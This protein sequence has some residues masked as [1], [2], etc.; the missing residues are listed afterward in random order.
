[1]TLFKLTE[2]TSCREEDFG[3][4]VYNRYKFEIFQIDN[5]GL[6]ILQS[7]KEENGLEKSRLQKLFD[8]QAYETQKA[9]WDFIAI[10]TN[11]GVLEEVAD[12]G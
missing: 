10:M 5:N 2:G 7:C 4:L 6:K 1:M 12:N 11:L 9:V 3:G 8:G